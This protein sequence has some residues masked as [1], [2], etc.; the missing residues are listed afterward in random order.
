VT[1]PVALAQLAADADGEANVDRAVQAVRA[2]ARGG[3]RLVALP[4]YAAGWA[5]RLGPELAQGA[6][7]VFERSIRQVAA[8]ENVWVVAGTMRPVPGRPG[9]SQNVALLVGPDGRT[10]GEYV[11]VHLFDALGVRES[12]VLDAGEPG[13]ANLLVQEIEGVRVG[14]ATCYDLRFPEMF[15]LLA[16]GGAEVIVVIAAWA[17][18]PGKVEQLQTLTRA[19]ALENTAYLLLASQSGR[20]RAGNSA[21]LDPLGHPRQ[22]AGGEEPALLHDDLDTAEVAR[23]RE[24]L[25]SLTHRRFR[26]VPGSPGMPS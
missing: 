19:R 20:G 5:P 7:G 6:D 8:E 18:G 25:P 23:V 2:A 13:A 21:V 24:S 4:E 15:R 22:E 10:A 11:K 26:V 17:A 14:V 3:A 16:D 9:R 12:D 1:L